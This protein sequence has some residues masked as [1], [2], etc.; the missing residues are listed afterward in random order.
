MGSLG[1]V[2]NLG[3]IYNPDSFT[4]DGS[5]VDFTLT[6]L[7]TSDQSII[8][9]E[10]GVIQKPGVD[11][12]ISGLTLTRT[13]APANLVA[14]FAMY[15]GVSLDIGVP[16]DGTVT[17]AKM[18]V[19]SVD[20]DQ[21]VDG[22]IDAVHMSANSIDS[23]AYVDASIDNSHLADDAV[24]IDELSATGTASSSTFLRG[25]NAWA[26]AGSP[27]I[28]DNGTEEAINI[29]VNE[30]V[31][32]PKQ[33]G[34]DAH[35]TSDTDNVTGDGTT[36]SLATNIWTEL[37]DKNADFVDGT[38]TAPVSGLYLL[39]FTMYNDNVLNTITTFDV[40]LA[41]SN[42]GRKFYLQNVHGAV[43][44]S[45]SA[46][47]AALIAFMDASDTA[48]VSVQIAG[49]AKSVDIEGGDSANST[50]FSGALLS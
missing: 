39:T 46:M 27:S 12:T 17:L 21:Y 32:M 15:L 35:V 22:S 23:D 41:L 30:I 31:T 34:F 3:Q 20:S 40:I 28:T 1:I 9:I 48:S 26:A 2:P 19:N 44:G 33:P 45:N 14:C 38:F 42:S 43:V 13:T 5:E 49:Q 37:S 24:G 50:R 25:D 4:G 29:D 8:W 10:G 47:S 18:A 16:S 7:V 36:Y 11:F 6:H